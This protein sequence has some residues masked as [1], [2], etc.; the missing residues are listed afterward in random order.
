MP[1]R[2]CCETGIP[3]PSRMCLHA[4]GGGIGLMWPA[5]FVCKK[6]SIMVS[7]IDEKK[8]LL[9]SLVFARA[10]VVVV[11]LGG[12]AANMHLHVR[13]WWCWVGGDTFPSCLH[14]QGWWWC[15]VVTWPPRVCTC[16]G[17]G[18]EWVVTL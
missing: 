3:R 4:G 17:G 12:D 11:V 10:R 15:W 6:W 18:G 14:A 7:N 8:N 13:G 5:A 9:S 2:V 1:S 16:K